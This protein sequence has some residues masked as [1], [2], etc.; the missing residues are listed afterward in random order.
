MSQHPVRFVQ[1]I[2]EAVALPAI[3]EAVTLQRIVESVA[4]PRI[5]EAVALHQIVEAVALQL[6]SSGAQIDTTL[7]TPGGD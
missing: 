7:L 2:V 3:A 4:L 5:A 6:A 1:G